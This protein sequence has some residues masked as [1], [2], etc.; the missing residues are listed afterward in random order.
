MNQYFSAELA[1]KVSRGMKE[2]RRKGYFQGGALLY[3]YKLDGRKI[4]IDEFNSE[5][6]KFVYEQYSK[7]VIVKD[8]ISELTAKGITKNGVE[9]AQNSV[10]NIL[11]NEKYSGVYM[12]GEEVIDNMYPQIVPKETY[13]I[14]REKI[15]K[16]RYGRKCVHVDFLLRQKITCG[17]CG[18]SINGESGTSRNGQRVYYY[19]CRGRKKHLANCDK[20]VIR[21]EELEKIVLDTVIQELSKAKTIKTIV[22]GLLDYQNTEITANSNLSLLTKQKKQVDTAL[23]NLLSA[24]ERG[25]ISNTTNKRLK[26][27]EQQQEDLERQ[28]LIERSKT[29]IKLSESE[30]RQYYEQALNLE[31]Q[32]L[33]NYLIK[34]IVLFDDKIE[35]HFNSPIRKSPDDDNQ[36]FLFYSKLIKFNLQDLL[37]E[38]YA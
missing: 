9:F 8:I 22:N 23:N 24:I 27:L 38:M 21:K 20:S 1:Q 16:N 17:Y 7:G 12:H 4:V 15:N 26:E 3:G 35:I 13:D 14:V 19:K 37:F 2:T 34:Q 28:I 32:M 18:H 5:V 33:I 29:T 36:G 25:V 11:K 10:Y 31:P 6:V 30:I